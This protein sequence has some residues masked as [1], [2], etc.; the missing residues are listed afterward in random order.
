MSK[1][2]KSDLI[3]LLSVSNVVPL[4]ATVISVAIFLVRMDSGQ[5]LIRYKIEQLSLKLDTYVEARQTASLKMNSQTEMRNGQIA[6]L[7]VAV[8]QCCPN[9]K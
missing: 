9:Y 8:A 7:Q 2:R 1:G 5:E 4:L 3:Q 6:D